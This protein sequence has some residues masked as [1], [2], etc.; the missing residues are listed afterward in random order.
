MSGATS[1]TSRVT[2]VKFSATSIASPLAETSRKGVE[3][4]ARVVHQDVDATEPIAGR[5][6]ESLGR[7]RLTH[8]GRGREHLSPE[9]LD[10][11]LHD[12]QLIGAQVAKSDRGAARRQQFRACP[13]DPAR[14]T[15]DDRGASGEVQ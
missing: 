2:D 6:H 12:R 1:R 5:R 13:A 14:R 9:L 10:A 4:A 15:R 8:V 7:H 11:C 3:A